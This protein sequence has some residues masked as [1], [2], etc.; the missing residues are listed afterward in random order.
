MAFSPA[1]GCCYTLVGVDD[2]KEP[3]GERKRENARECERAKFFARERPFVLEVST[4]CTRR[5]VCALALSLSPFCCG[6]FRSPSLSVSLSLRVAVSFTL[7]AE[8][9]RNNSLPA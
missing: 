2:A 4:E 8:T 7:V 5:V 9:R 6:R 3:R 1:A